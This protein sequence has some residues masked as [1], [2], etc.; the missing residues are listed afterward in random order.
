MSNHDVFISYS[1]K[2]RP[3]ADQIREVLLQNGIACWMAPY[4]IPGASDYAKEIPAAIE[5]CR[6]FVLLLSENS[7]N[8][9]YVPLELGQ[10]FQ[11]GK[12]IVPFALDSCPLTDDFDFIL[13]R[14]QR[15]DAFYDKSAALSELVETIRRLLTPAPAPR[16]K[17]SRKAITAICI[18]AAVVLVAAAALLFGLNGADK[19]DP[20]PPT[21][22]PTDEPPTEPPTQSP[23]DAPTIDDYVT[24]GA[25]KTF[26]S[27]NSE[28]VYRVPRFLIDS[29]DG[30]AANEDIEDEYNENFVKASGSSQNY[31]SQGL[32]GIDYTAALYGDVVSVMITRRYDANYYDNRVYNFDASTGAQL[33]NRAMIKK[34]GL[35]YGEMEDAFMDTLLEDYEYKYGDTYAK[36]TQFYNATLSANSFDK[37]KLYISEDNML[38][39]AAEEKIGAGSG[40]VFVWLN[41]YQLP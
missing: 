6:V 34:L 3:Q 26:F 28:I 40:T 13:S 20:V 21:S 15:I 36:Q 33:S 29:L 38:S 41:F 31:V 30:E 12:T 9:K 16:K 23:T 14:S 25:E 39:V 17:T 2:D 19:P 4:D 27:E 24:V 8:S 5:G 1:S 18:I 7:Q 37:V 22:A 35:D 11:K 10:A 32:M